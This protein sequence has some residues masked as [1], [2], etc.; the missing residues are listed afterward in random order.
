M[1]GLRIQGWQTIG[2]HAPQ[3]T[4]HRGTCHMTTRQ[5]D[6]TLRHTCSQA[7]KSLQRDDMVRPPYHSSSSTQSTSHVHK[8]QGSNVADVTRLVRNS[9]LPTASGKPSACVISGSSSNRRSTGDTS[10]CSDPH[11]VCLVGNISGLV[12]VSHGKPTRDH[13]LR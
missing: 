3:T 5:S 2:C 13:E 11:R 10:S 7:E 4:S 1:S 6:R 12:P 9:S 8:A